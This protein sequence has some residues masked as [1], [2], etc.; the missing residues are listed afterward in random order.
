M[1][2]QNQI[3]QLMGII[4]MNHVLFIATQI[5]VEMLSDSELELL[6]QAGVNINEISDTPFDEMFRWGMLSNAIGNKRAKNL[7]YSQ[8][9]NFL[10]SSQYLPLTEV[11]K[12]AKTVA[13]K[14]AA[15][16]LRGLGNRIIQQTNQVLIEA[17]QNQRAQ[18]EKIVTDESV[19][20]IKNRGTISNLVSNLGHKTGDW[21]R[22][23]GRISDYV[24][25]QA[26][27]EGR[28]AQIKTQFGVESI[29][30]KKVFQSACKSCV[31]LYLTDGFGSKPK[32]FKL[33]E[34][35]NNGTNIGRKV[36][37]WKPVIGPTHPWCRCMLVYI[38]PNYEWDDETKDFNKPKQFERKVERTSRV[39]V[40]IGNQSIEV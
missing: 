33:T 19:K 9:K 8:F 7:T 21:A 18:Y 29:V 34:L 5:G 30:Y 35:Q 24:M 10:S 14:Q 36:A 31:K 27:E 32:V 22:D 11:E 23:F 40:N 2:T 26:F 20:N 39:R 6:K 1:F 4:N 15:S 38:D 28:A 16:D 25:H 17:D 13:K 12:V 37:E 3:E